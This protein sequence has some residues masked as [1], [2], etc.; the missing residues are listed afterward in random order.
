VNWLVEL[1]GTDYPKERQMQRVLLIAVVVLLF[2]SNLAQAEDASIKGVVA[3]KGMPFEG[4]ITFHAE[5]KQ[6][7]GSPIAEDGKY[8]ID[9][10]RPGKYKV[11]FE[12][13]GISPKYKDADTTPIVI[14]VKAGK[15]ADGDFSLD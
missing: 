11:T 3:Y 15:N 8:A 7:V 10:L 4:K 2:L 12:G 1:E 14:E 9:L 5:N 6:F 13:K